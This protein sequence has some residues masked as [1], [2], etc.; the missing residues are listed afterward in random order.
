MYVYI[1]VYILNVLAMSST[2]KKIP[3][4][5]VLPP[6]HDQFFFQRHQRPPPAYHKI[7]NI[8]IITI[9]EKS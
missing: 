8:F 5:L 7:K 4:Q 3:V 1:Y 6:V 9:R 2:K